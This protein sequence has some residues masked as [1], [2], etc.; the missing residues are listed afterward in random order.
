MFVSP[1][2]ETWVKRRKREERRGEREREVYAGRG[3]VMHIDDGS[4]EF[5]IVSFTI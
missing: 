5:F 2:R 4:Y 1:P 3:R